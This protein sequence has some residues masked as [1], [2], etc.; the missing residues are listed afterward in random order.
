MRVILTLIV[1]FLCSLTFSQSTFDDVFHL[2]S[3][4]IMEN[5]PFYHEFFVHDINN[6]GHFEI[7]SYYQ[8]LECFEFNGRDFGELNLGKLGLYKLKRLD[9]N[10][11]QDWDNDGDVDIVAI[12]K[13]DQSL[14]SELL[15]FENNGAGNFSENVFNNNILLLNDLSYV[16]TCDYNFDGLSDLFLYGYTQMNDN[17]LF[18]FNRQSFSAFGRDSIKQSGL[19]FP[20]TIRDV[21][22]D[23]FTD[24]I[25]NAGYLDG[26][27]DFT[28]VEWCRGEE[29]VGP[30]G[31]YKDFN[32]DG[33][34]DFISE[35]TL[36]LSNK[37]TGCYKR[38]DSGIFI[39]E[40]WAYDWNN[41]GWTDL[42]GYHNSNV[43][44]YENNK[45]GGF[46]SVFQKHIM[47][48]PKGFLPTDLDQDG[49]IDLIMGVNGISYFENIIE[50][51]RG[52]QLKLTRS[53]PNFSFYNLQVKV[54]TGQSI[55]VKHYKVDDAVESGESVYFH[56]G[57]GTINTIDSIQVNWPSGLT[58]TIRE[59]PYSN[60]IE[61]IEDYNAKP[62][63]V[64]TLKGTVLYPDKAMLEWENNQ[65]GEERFIIQRKRPTDAGFVSIDTIPANSVNFLDN[66]YLAKQ[67]VSY[68]VIGES[69]FGQAESNEVALMFGDALPA[70][71]AAPSIQ[72]D[73]ISYD[74]VILSWNEIEDASEYVIE[75]KDNI[76]NSYKV[77]NIVDS[78]VLKYR[79]DSVLESSIYTYRVTASNHGTYSSSSN[80]IEASVPYSL[81][82]LSERINL[83]PH[84]LWQIMDYNG[85]GDKDFYYNF[86]DYNDE[87]ATGSYVYENI[88]GTN[89]NENPTK[90]ARY[91]PHR[92][93]SYPMPFYDFNKD[94]LPEIYSSPDTITTLTGNGNILF[95]KDSLEIED[96][97]LLAWAGY[98]N[99]DLNLD[100]IYRDFG[101][102]PTANVYVKLSDIQRKGDDLLYNSHTYSDCFVVNDWNADGLN[103][104]LVARNFNRY[105]TLNYLKNGNHE[106]SKSQITITNGSQ[107]SSIKDVT[108]L[109]DFDFNN[110]GFFDLYIQRESDGYILTNNNNTDFKIS[111]ILKNLSQVQLK[112]FN[113]DG[114]TDLIGYNSENKKV[115]SY[116]NN[117]NGDFEI[118]HYDFDKVKA[119]KWI[120]SDDMDGDGDVDL[121]LGIDEYLPLVENYSRTEKVRE[122]W[123]FSNQIIEEQA[124]EKEKLPI[125]AN[126]QVELNGSGASFSWEQNST[127]SNL[128]YNIYLKD[129][130]GDY[131]ISSVT[132]VDNGSDFSS[133]GNYWSNSNFFSTTC[134][135]NGTYYWAVQTVD[136][137]GRTSQFSE[138]QSFSITQPTLT[139]PEAFQVDVLSPTEINMYWSTEDKNVEFFEVQRKKEGETAFETIDLRKLID[140]FYTDIELDPNTTYS[141]RV[142]AYN[143]TNESD[144]TET[145]T[146][147]TP[148]YIYTPSKKYPILIS[149]SSS[150]KMADFDNN[151]KSDFIINND[152]RLEIYYSINDTVS[153][154]EYLDLTPY[155]SP[156]YSKIDFK[157]M[158]FD[159]NGYI[160]IVLSSSIPKTNDSLIINGFLNDGKS[161]TLT[162]LD[163]INIEGYNNF[164]IDDLDNDGDWDYYGNF[165]LDGWNSTATIII[166][167]NSTDSIFS[168]EGSFIDR[169][170]L[171]DLDQDGYKDIP[172]TTGN[173]YDENQEVLLISFSE[174]EEWQ[175]KTL[176]NGHWA[177]NREL[178][179]EFTDWNNDGWIDIFTY[180][181]S[182]EDRYQ[183]HVLENK[184]G[185]SFEMRTPYSDVALDYEPYLNVI[186]INGDDRSDA[187]FSGKRLNT[188]QNR[189]GHWVMLADLN[190][191]F[192]SAQGPDLLF[193]FYISYS[194]FNDID[195]DGDPELIVYNDDSY[196]GNAG[197]EIFK[198]NYYPSYTN[199]WR[200]PLPPIQLKREPYGKSGSILSWEN[201]INENNSSN[202][203]NVQI[204]NE[205]GDTIVSAESLDSGKRQIQN[206]GNSGI[207][208]F[209]IVNDL[210]VGNYTWKVQAINKSM[211]ASEFSEEAS[212][213]QELN[214]SINNTTID[215]IANVD[216][217]NKTITLA[218]QLVPSMV[219]IY[220]IQGRILFNQKIFSN[221][222]DLNNLANAS[223]FIIIELIVN[224]KV[225]HQKILW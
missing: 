7:L 208:K 112:D 187:I 169:K 146:V 125:P 140:T 62:Q 14:Q 39:D 110:D 99:D 13:D 223:N 36:W 161:F 16:N 224:N 91:L 213:S 18:L 106:I 158:D 209:F 10:N 78:T 201:D 148:P 207:N 34:Y 221:K 152:D 220:D 195:G 144:Y 85:D 64:N 192:L 103:D 32:N 35:Y 63:P 114:Y 188:S 133:S 186:D 11:F 117:H 19:H 69:K 94:N 51:N 141:Y 81:F 74:L 153:S 134:L 189:Y 211:N 90:L 118:E 149:N 162:Q 12:E 59:I 172:M 57:L 130:T 70:P 58:Q 215:L 128:K 216:R 178:F 75:R 30:D 38:K 194:D 42:I 166:N 168:F 127:L 6:N 5:P 31:L 21:N 82:E 119:P 2:K 107:F 131:L 115:E 191:N 185:L 9:N 108:R 43:Y 173:I 184:E 52:I 190:K 8:G 67:T 138:E 41:D 17:K 179:L 93:N 46:T 26:G 98:L 60:N 88:D 47:S 27:N 154:P 86:N 155:T 180:T 123:I 80:E 61:I 197:I 137:D 159:K 72:L 171:I 129:A 22:H 198:N 156:F 204:L 200:E 217:K 104:I 3:E 54:F 199:V 45:S 124:L 196:G 66:T 205:A 97:H 73:S 96:K 100:Y 157:L 210:P 68:K 71:N 40:L 79:D 164:Y 111:H 49:D 1:L 44:F 120:R 122:I 116:I 28:F 175:T 77:I 84:R 222:L 109:D 101:S 33:I 183:F 143:C 15:F 102:Y 150:P 95:F 212:F 206:Y 203:Y 170:Y 20:R 167:T 181:H 37:E 76:A 23:N 53:N 225:Y 219:R 50:T 145:I 56:F 136:K 182:D 89:F 214:N 139:K 25:I 105:L 160:D 135:N 151:G 193:H 177:N 132:S 142:S 48:G 113:N 55:Q 174:K 121:I 87:E 147:K 165:S 126:L 176:F 163:T 4:H 202:F 83:A 218:N 65:Y 92:Y 29:N 24:I